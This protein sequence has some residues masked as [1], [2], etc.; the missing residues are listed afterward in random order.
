[1]VEVLGVVEMHAA[2]AD[3]LVEVLGELVQVVVVVEWRL[4]LLLLLLLLMK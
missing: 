4:L 3:Q 2:L 1:M